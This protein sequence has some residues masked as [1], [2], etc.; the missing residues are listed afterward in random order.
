MATAVPGWFDADHYAQQKVAQMNST[1]YEKGWLAKNFDGASEWTTES[2]N[3][4]LSEYR[5]PDGKPVTAYENFL[6][7][8]M[9]GYGDHVR[10]QDINV[11]GT[12]LFDVPVYIHNVAEHFNDSGFSANGYPK[13]QWTDGSALR[14]IYN[15]LHMSAWDHFTT[16]G[17]A[18]Q[19]DPSNDF[20]TSA[21]LNARA[22]AMGASVA[23]ALEDMLESGGNPI[24]DQHEFGA[25]HHIDARPVPH[26]VTPDAEL[27]VWGVATPPADDKPSTP[28]PPVTPPSYGGGSSTPSKPSET[29]GDDTPGGNEPGGDEETGYENTVEI[30]ADK[31]VYDEAL[32]GSTLYTAIAGGPDGTLGQDYQITGPENEENTL[33][34]DLAEP[35]AGFNGVADGAN[36]TNISRLELVNAAEADDASL[37]FDA[38]NTG[39][40]TNYALDMNGKTGDIKIDNISEYTNSFEFSNLG[41]PNQGKVTLNYGVPE[42]SGNPLGEATFIFTDGAGSEDAPLIIEGATDKN[43]PVTI[44]SDQAVNVDVSG[45]GAGFVTVQGKGDIHVANTGYTA[46]VETVG[47]VRKTVFNTN[48]DADGIRLVERGFGAVDGGDMEININGDDIFTSTVSTDTTGNVVL[49]LAAEAEIDTYHYDSAFPTVEFQAVNAER[50]TANLNGTFSGGAFTVGKA[51]DITAPNGMGRTEL[52][53]EK[54]G[55]ASITAGSDIDI[56]LHGEARTINVDWDGTAEKASLFVDGSSSNARNFDISAGGQEIVCYPGKLLKSDNADIMVKIR[57]AGE[58]TVYHAKNEGGNVTFDIEAEGVVHLAEATAADGDVNVTVKAD[59]IT[60][61]GGTANF[62][63]TGN[64]VSLDYSQ[65]ATTAMAAE[66]PD[67]FAGTIPGSVISANDVI[68]Y[69]GAAE[70]DKVTVMKLGA[71]TSTID[72]GTGEDFISFNAEYGNYGIG[73]DLTAIAKLTLD[74]GEADHVMVK[75]SSNGNL[76]VLIDGWTEGNAIQVD[77]SASN[78]SEAVTKLLQD[79]GLEFDDET[80]AALQ[81]DGQACHDGT[82]YAL[83]SDASGSL[84]LVAVNGVTDLAG[85]FEAI[86]AETPEA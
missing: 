66:I 42:D 73:I 45:Y 26:P 32:K 68:T 72:T 31:S 19:L 30:T 67:F 84:T 85:V 43:P 29:P 47:G 63:A 37:E 36:V 54:A 58:A 82:A 10:L 49:N 25:K 53:F 33:H 15:E 21:Y 24:T 46:S 65:V 64:N 39:L 62:I 41:N 9:S 18:R 86:A 17:A 71:E 34:I 11:S 16:Y 14:Y 61:A 6:A 4:Y 5:T 8:N 79:C 74:S 28:Q 40:V 12:P 77:T 57:E 69:K 27:N 38:A 22:K 80:L 81:A 76:A 59:S 23:E 3:K 50:F 56:R 20:D 48:G 75:G 7:C 70:T 13:G 60:F 83:N 52:T 1:N 44:E 51:I 2:Y 55:D 78:D 35:W